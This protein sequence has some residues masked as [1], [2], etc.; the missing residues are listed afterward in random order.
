[1]GKLQGQD[2]IALI[3]FLILVYLLVVNWKGAN[4]LLAT[5]A[6]AG[7]GLIRTLQGR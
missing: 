1:M 4:A 5:A 6:S 2:T 7:G 3:G